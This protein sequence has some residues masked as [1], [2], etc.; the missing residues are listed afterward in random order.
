VSETRY[1]RIL[2]VHVVGAGATELIG[3]AVL[4]MELEATVREYAQ[5]LR[6]H[7]TFS[8]TLVEAAR[9]AAGWALYLPR[10]EA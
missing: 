4:A 8:E 6:V 1:G 10:R 7:P 3:E 9:D 2:G 5:S